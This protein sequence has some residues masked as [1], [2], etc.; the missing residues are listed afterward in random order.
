MAG[1]GALGVVASGTAVPAI[2]PLRAI[3]WRFLL[4]GPIDRAFDH[5]LVLGGPRGVLARAQAA[6]LARRMS[7]ESPGRGTADLVAA[8]A[9]TPHEIRDI[10]RAVAR[11]GVLYLEVDRA[12]RGVRASTPARVAATLRREGL[13]SHAFYAMEPTIDEPR[14]FIPLEAPSAMTW[15]RRTSIGDRPLVR[16]ANA[17]RHSAV[18]VGGPSVAAF[19]RPY[20]VVAVAGEHD[21][22]AP[23]ALRHPVVSQS[24]GATRVP[25]TAVMLT[26]GG[27][28]VLL[29]PFDAGGRVPVGVVKVTKAESFVDR[30]E[31]E[32]ARMRVLR[33]ALDASLATAI[34]EPLGATRVG[35]SMVACERFMAG[36]SLAARAMNSAVA[37]DEKVADLQLGVAWLARFHRATETRRATIRESRTT[38]VDGFLASYAQALGTADDAALATRL[39]SIADTLGDAR[40]AI[41]TQH[42]D[43]AAWNVLRSDSGLAVV[44]WEG[45]TEGFAAFDAVH[46]ASTWLYSVRLSEGVDD[47]VRCV[48]E[49]L[50]PLGRDAVA[51]AARDAL[52]RYLEMVGIDQRLAPLLVALHRVELALRR[53]MQR[54]L[55]GEPPETAMATIETRVVQS[56]AVQAARLFPS[57]DS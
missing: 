39:G 15:H 5:L 16:I 13:T 52:I 41:A 33:S 38:L 10:A 23:G 20:A 35:R 22:L 45:A 12:R 18:R 25:S 32:Q 46:L 55:Q 30:T 48:H 28:R 49:L 14:A 57:A 51:S 1:T 2:A 11:D 6:G 3:D 50:D 37:V 21:D 26:Y 47:E 36:T 17:V 53:G 4:P 29:F 43:F 56:L 40:I 7:T 24:L 8:Y 27:D 31:N 44:D 54:R 9:D 42:R 34:P 19:D